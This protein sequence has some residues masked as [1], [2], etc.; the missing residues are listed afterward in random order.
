MKPRHL[1]PIVV[2]LGAAGASVS[3]CGTEEPP[4]PAP[5]LVGA[6]DDPGASPNVTRTEPFEPA[7]P[8]VGVEPPIPPPADPPPPNPPPP[9]D[10]L[11]RPGD[12][13]HL[14]R[15]AGAPM[16]VQ[17]QPSPPMAPRS[18]G[19]PASNL[20]RAPAPSPA[21]GAVVTEV[22]ITHNHPP[23]TACTPISDEELARAFGDLR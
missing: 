13:T 15:L 20:D 21:H 23:G 6:K 11:I 3:G 2:G 19:A 10:V 5:V 9:R 1:L 7:R 14:P 18:S 4:P 12:R 8:P 17:R 22:R 16:P